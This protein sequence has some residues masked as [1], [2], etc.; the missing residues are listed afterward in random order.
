MRWILILASIF[1]ASTIIIGA[2]RQH[3]TSVSDASDAYQILQ[4]GLKYHQLHSV[5]LLALG[6]YGL[7]QSFNKPLAIS[8]VLFSAGIII[9]S[10]GLYGMII[11]NLPVL[12]YL[13]PIGGVIFILAWGSLTFIKSKK[14]NEE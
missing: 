9:F 12:G 3:I 11:F 10:G 5:V 1:G 14:P 4:T 7:N 13:T 6:L 2:A 8:A